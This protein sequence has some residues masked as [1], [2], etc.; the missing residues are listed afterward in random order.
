MSVGRTLRFAGASLLGLLLVTPVAAQ[1]ALPTDR[2][3]GAV[4]NALDAVD[5]RLGAAP[6]DKVGNDLFI[7]DDAECDLGQYDI[8]LDGQFVITLM[9]YD[10]P[11]DAAGFDIEVTAIERTRV[12]DALALINCELGQ[13]PVEREADDI[14]EVRDVECDAGQYDVRLNAEFAIVAI[15]LDIAAVPP[16]PLPTPIGPPVAQPAPPLQPAPP[17]LQPAPPIFQPAPPIQ[18]VQVQVTVNLNLRIEPSNNALVIIVIPAGTIVPAYR[19]TLDYQWCEVEYQGYVGWVS[20]SYIVSVELRQPIVDVGPRLGIAVIEFILG[21]L[22]RPGP[23]QVCFYADFNYAGGGFCATT[24]TEEAALAANWNDRI[25][26]LRL[27]ANVPSV[28]VCTD[29]QFAGTCQVFQ[30]DVAQLPGN[31]NDAISSFRVPAPGGQPPPQAVTPAANEVC[32]YADFDFAGPSF[33]ATNGT[34]TAALGAEWTDRISSLR[35]GTNVASVQVCTDNQY[36]GTCQTFQ[37]NVAQLPGNLND[38]ISSFRIPAPGAQPP[39]GPVTPAATEVCF[40][41]DFN[42]GGAAFCVPTG[43]T[44]AAIPADWNDRISSIQLGTQVPSLEVCTD[45]NFAGT[46]EVLDADATELA[47]NLNDNISSLR[48]PAP[49]APAAAAEQPPA[50]PQ[51]PAA[52]QPQPPP[53]GQQP[54]AQQPPAGEAPQPPPAAQ[55]PAP[56]PPEPP[57]PQPPPPAPEARA[58]G[59]NEVCF[60]ADFDYA[61]DAYCAAN[62]TVETALG[63]TWNDRFSS[64]RL[65]NGVASVQV[66][67]DNEFGG[68]CQVFTGNA[69]QLPGN[70]NDNISSFR[71]PAPA[72]EPAAPPAAAPAA[73]PGPAPGGVPPGGAAPPPGG[74]GAEPPPAGGGVEP[75]PAGGAEPPPPG[76]AEPPPPP[77]GGGAG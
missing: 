33:C 42:F 67:T 3:V 69:A 68:A 66:C 41:A 5:C 39:P 70:L 62:G 46:C 15:A 31:L 25:S 76:G 47:G 63:G 57:A 23:N 59:G 14:I 49:A 45:N 75:P 52:E 77:P 19:C 22:S 17:P 7:V 2:E 58:P 12:A 34:T 72:P 65:G 29:N 71:I 24:G 21:Q 43:T 61:G 10:G 13:Q 16:M 27:G 32:F 50:A 55:Q 18:V 35:L 20:A 44:T 74:G 51:P 54:P 9:A 8:R 36:A 6:V 28:Q 26:S 40:Y 11:V 30:D 53:A 60:Y 37:T 56:Q 73:P 4:V 1:S 48:I 38:A 64:I